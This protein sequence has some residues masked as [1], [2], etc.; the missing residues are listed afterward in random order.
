MMQEAPQ[1][2]ASI[3]CIY[4]KRVKAQIVEDL[5]KG[6]KDRFARLQQDGSLQTASL[7]SIGRQCATKIEGF[8]LDD[9]MFAINLTSDEET[10]IRDVIALLTGNQKKAKGL[11][12]SEI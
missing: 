12:K 8:S 3:D 10:K 11:Q 1:G 5:F 6:D 7:L 2:F 4:Q 9:R